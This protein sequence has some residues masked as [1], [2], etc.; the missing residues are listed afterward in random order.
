MVMAARS[1]RKAAARLHWVASPADQRPSPE[2]LVS[3]FMETVNWH[4]KSREL[5]SLR[6]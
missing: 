5:P 6:V 1:L 3:A 4:E 2:N